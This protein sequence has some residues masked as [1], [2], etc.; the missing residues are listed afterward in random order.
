MS[1]PSNKEIK[2]ALHSYFAHVDSHNVEDFTGSFSIFVHENCEEKIK[3]DETAF[4][5][6]QFVG[7]DMEIVANAL[8]DA[9]QESC[10]KSNEFKERFFKQLVVQMPDDMLSALF[11]EKNGALRAVAIELPKGATPEQLAEIIGKH[12]SEKIKEESAKDKH[13]FH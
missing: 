2:H 5:I 7:G 13:T 9:I 4:H 12:V 3:N 10:E 1:R 8:V 11:E 6:C